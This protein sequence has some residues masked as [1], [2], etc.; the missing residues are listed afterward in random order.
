ML[1]E[2][3]FPVRLDLADLKFPGPPPQ[4]RGMRPGSILGPHPE[5]LAAAQHGV[6]EA[7]AVRNRLGAEPGVAEHSHAFG[8]EDSQVAEAA[9]PLI[10]A[11]TAGA[12]SSSSEPDPI[13]RAVR[14]RVSGAP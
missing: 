8:Q 6:D 10:Q 1:F 5:S 12:E 14:R 11:I 13:S 7:A 3:S 2:R 4:L 9:L